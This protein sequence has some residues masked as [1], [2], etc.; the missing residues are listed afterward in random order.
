MSGG[1][2]LREW[3]SYLG[4]IGVRDLRRPAP[5]AI[6]EVEQVH[7]AEKSGKA[8]RPARQMMIGEG[9]DS[10]PPEDP[11]VRLEEIRAEI[12]ECSRC[13]LCEQRKNIVFGDGSP[14]AGLM[15]IGEG[16]GADEDEQGLPFVG[17]AGKKLDEMIRA[18][19]LEREEVYIANI[20]KCRPPRNR[21]PERDEI[22]TC[23]KFLY[24][25]IEAIRPKV[26]VTLGA[27]ATKTLLNTK[28]GITK[29]RGE[30]HSF[31]GT[32]VMPTFHPAYLLRAYTYENRAKVYDDLKAAR[33]RMDELS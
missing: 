4:E 29:I 8:S 20:V 9:Y 30:W 11:A 15:F 23:V 3:I 7:A 17:R 10:P 14:S 19:G 33:K 12:G 31:Q 28:I 2:D 24:H 6:A 25:Q 5:V 26:I 18:I 1:R 16:P 22:S 21:D 27:P 13:K 32:D